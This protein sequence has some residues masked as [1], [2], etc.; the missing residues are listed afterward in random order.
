MTRME[1][2]FGE[3]I[4]VYTR[5]EAIEDGA[6]VDVTGTA[7]EAGIVHPVALTAA[8]WHDVNDI[9]GSRPCPTA[10]RP[11]SALTR[12]LSRTWTAG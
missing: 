7:E 5:A 3:P 2:I 1:E 10:G 11:L 8:L 6:L 9:P 12:K 4:H